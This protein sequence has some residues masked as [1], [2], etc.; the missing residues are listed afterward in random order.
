MAELTQE[1]LRRY[2][3]QFLNELTNQDQQG[4]QQ[5]N[6]DVLQAAADDAK[7]QFRTEGG[8][9][10]DPTNQQHIQVCSLGVIY[11]LHLY[12]GR[13][14]DAL[15][16]ARE[17]WINALRRFSVRQGDR[18]RMLP[19]TTSPL[20]PSTQRQGTRPDF[21]RSRWDDVVP[22]MPGAAEVSDDASGV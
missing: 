20:S 19:V 16:Q 5:V 6:Q 7:A 12:T 4:A 22:E 18:A 13:Y 2:S 11:F 3:R 8:T 15:S 17:G 21:D 14:T 1:V 10:Y 9:V